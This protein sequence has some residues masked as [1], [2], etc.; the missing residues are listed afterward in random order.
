M[1]RCTQK[2]IQHTEKKYKSYLNNDK[3]RKTVDPSSSDPI[4]VRGGIDDSNIPRGLAKLSLAH[5]KNLPLTAGMVI[6]ILG[7]G[8]ALMEDRL[9]NFLLENKH[10]GLRRIMQLVPSKTYNGYIRLLKKIMTLTH[11]RR[12]S[13]LLAELNIK[14]SLEQGEKM[15]GYRLLLREF[16]S[17]KSNVVI[18]LVFIAT[19]VATANI[20]VF[21]N[22]MAFINYKIRNG[23]I[24]RGV[25]MYLL[26]FL[27]SQNIEVPDEIRES[28]SEVVEELCDKESNDELEIQNIVETIKI[29]ISGPN[30]AERTVADLMKPRTV[31]FF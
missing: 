16:F 12:H 10:L 30:S 11:S 28:I 18:L 9:L 23:S 21:M 19:Y 8:D 26:D 4:N 22:M 20:P 3:L 27:K 6:V 17:S 15:A 14:P 25:G 13:E 2:F 31:R 7:L 24:S 5:R 1:A 29:Y